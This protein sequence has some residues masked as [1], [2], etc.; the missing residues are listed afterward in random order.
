[1][2]IGIVT[3]FGN[4]NYGNRLQ[5]FALQEVLAEKAEVET[6]VFVKN[7]HN[8]KRAI[9]KF[10]EKK[11]GRL[12]LIPFSNLIRENKISSFSKKYIYTKKYNLES[13]KKN[14][15]INNEYDLFVVGSDQVWNPL[16]WGENKESFEFYKF[17]LKFASDEKKYAYAASFGINDIPSFWKKMFLDELMKFQLISV[18]EVEGQKII[19]NYL[20]KDVPVVLDPTMLLTKEQWEIKL[21]LDEKKGNYILHFFLGSIEKNIQDYIDSIDESNTIY[22]SD[23]KKKEYMSNPRDFVNYI[24]NAKLVLTDSFH[25]TVFSIIFHV[26]F[27][28]FSRKGKKMNMDSRI[29]TLLDITDLENRMYKNEKIDIFNCDYSGVDEKLKVERKK[30]L[31]YLQRIVSK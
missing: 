13:I 23:E 4:F 8:F 26:P 31:E 22:L 9:K 6:L 20:N 14:E 25:A 7:N 18:R 15:L 27:V 3:L 2:K 17:F 30:S 19:K 10:V 12:R 28:V 29:N 24:K 21:N 11:N 1:M 5:N 16:F